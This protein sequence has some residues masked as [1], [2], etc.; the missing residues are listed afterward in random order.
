MARTT[1]ERMTSNDAWVLAS[2]TLQ[3]GKNMLVCSNTVH[4]RKCQTNT[5][6]LHV[7]TVKI[8]YGFH[9]ALS[10]ISKIK[11]RFRRVLY[12]NK[13]KYQNAR[14]VFTGFELNYWVLLLHPSSYHSQN[15]SNVFHFSYLNT[16]SWYTLIKTDHRWR[17]TTLPFKICFA[18]FI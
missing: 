9:F 15:A 8:L 12:Q 13:V 7:S 17:K 18:Q 6:I 3:L 5:V 1:R 14:W 4:I 11:N 10:V 16:R 2:A